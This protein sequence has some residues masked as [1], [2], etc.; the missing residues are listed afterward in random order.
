[1][2]LSSEGQQS[3]CSKE[4]EHVL[5][6]LLRLFELKKWS[7]IGHQVMLSLLRRCI[8]AVDRLGDSGKRSS[9]GYRQICL[10][11][12]LSIFASMKSRSLLESGHASEIASLGLWR[13]SPFWRLSAIA[14][15]V[16]P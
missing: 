12:C 4:V 5:L 10:A 9:L 13:F 15:A 2:H 16:C 14:E 3:H 11:E 8:E 6:L 7:V 1:M